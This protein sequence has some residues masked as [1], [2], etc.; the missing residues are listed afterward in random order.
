MTQMGLSLLTD[1]ALPAGDPFWFLGGRTRVLVPGSATGSTMSV[2]EFDEVQGQAPPLHIHEGEEEVW[3]VSPRLRMVA[4]FA[5]AGIEEWFRKNG[6]PVS[7]PEEAPASFDIGAIVAS[8]EAF[9]LRVA[10]P[11]PTA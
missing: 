2:L 6:S 9:Q 3:I 4:V 1:F 8:A 7:S 10:G 11:P 5:P